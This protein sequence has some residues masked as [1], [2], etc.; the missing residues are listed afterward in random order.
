MRRLRCLNG[1]CTAVTFAE[2]VDRLTTPHARKTPLLRSVLGSIARTL[3]GRPGARLATLLGVRGE[4]HSAAAAG[5]AQ[6]SPRSSEHAGRGRFPAAQGRLVRATVLVNLEAHRPVDV[7]LGREAQSL[8]AWLAGHPEVE[9]ICRDR[10]G[11]YAEGART[12]APQTVQVADGWHLRRV[13]CRAE[14]GAPGG[15]G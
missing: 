15:A 5:R 10:A 6:F 8:A 11:A 12:G 4:G 3:A 1:A 14:R 13:R 9:T 7:L 2:Q